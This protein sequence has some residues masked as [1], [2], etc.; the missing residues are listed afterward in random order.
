MMVAG[1]QYRERK[2]GAE[3]PR[4][5]GPSLTLGVLFVSAI[6]GKNASL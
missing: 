1:E 4:G 6:V 5:L 2:R 3:H